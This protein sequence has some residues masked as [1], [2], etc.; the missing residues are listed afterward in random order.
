MRARTLAVSLSVALL[1]FF[2][3]STAR[4]G[5]YPHERDGVV[6]GFNL[7]GGSAGINVTGLDSNREGGFG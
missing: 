2:I 3:A 6:L 4:A 5:S 7:G 1:A